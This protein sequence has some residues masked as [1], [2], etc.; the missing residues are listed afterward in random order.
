[1]ENK[2]TLLVLLLATLSLSACKP[3]NKNSSPVVSSTPGDEWTTVVAQKKSTDAEEN[4]PFATTAKNSGKL[5]NGFKDFTSI[6]D[7]PDTTEESELL[8]KLEDYA[9]TTHNSGIP[10]MDNGGKTMYAERLQPAA[11][12]YITNFGYGILYG[13]ITEPLTDVQE[14]TAE[15]RSYYHTYTSLQP[16]RMFAAQ[17]D[18]N[19]ESSL[20]SYMDA[21]FYDI[22]LRP[23]KDSYEWYS[24]LATGVPEGVTGF[25]SGNSFTKYKITLRDDAKW[26]TLS[27]KY[28]E[29]NGAPITLDDVENSFRTL[30]TQKYGIYRATTMFDSAFTIVGAKNFYD[31]TKESTGTNEQ[32]ANVGL[33]FDKATNSFTVETSRPFTPRQLMV[34]L[35]G[36]ITSPLNKAYVTAL[37]DGNY[38][39]GLKKLGTKDVGADSVLS[40]GPF[41][42]QKWD[43]THLAYKRNPNYY[44]ADLYSIE[45]VKISVIETLAVAFQEFIKGSLDVCSIPA[46]Q[47]PTYVNDPRTKAVPGTSIWKINTNSLDQEQWNSRFG[48]DGYI[49]SGTDGSYKVKPIMSNLN[50][51]NGLYYSVDRKEIADSFGRNP[52][53]NYFSDAYILDEDTDVQYNQ[54][55]AAKKVIAK[56]NNLNPNTP[57]VETAP[58]GYSTAVA[59]Q[60][61]KTAIDQE[62]AKGTIKANDTIKLKQVWLNADVQTQ[63]GSY[64][65]KYFENTFNESNTLGIKLELEYSAPVAPASVYDVIKEGTFDL[66]WGSISGMT[67]DPIGFAEVLCSDNRTDFTLSHGYNTSVVDSRLEYKG[68]YYSFDALQQAASVGCAVNNGKETAAV[69]LVRTNY[70]LNKVGAEI[71]LYNAGGVKT[72]VTA[73]TL[74]DPE[75]YDED[76]WAVDEDWGVSGLLSDVYDSTNNRIV[77]TKE[78][79]AELG[80]EYKDGTYLWLVVYYVYEFAD[81]S[82][83]A[84][85]YKIIEVVL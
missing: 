27:T 13:T 3:T 30:I 48:K 58:L 59:K 26:S 16:K 67:L 54:T 12:K 66:A 37:G 85:A 84:E 7:N 68:E 5:A 17:G 39:E 79:A 57:D 23:S 63:Y 51:L 76:G 4:N 31:Q 14:P 29:F 65:K 81:G 20:T 71:S 44:D 46:D 77:V 35:S 73:I 28:A 69:N 53:Q 36:N 2:K 62:V 50:F 75:T 43:D 18:S 24:S 47:L 60:Y 78:Q 21:V 40:S 22:K 56:R 9:M 49:S 52:K 34:Q 83:S 80:F 32:W 6:A 15:Y 70:S 45:G 25:G 33:K 72:V 11:T 19:N 64:F 82:T 8:A 41:T 55:D 10:F 74:V 38:E 61:F 42:L 1:M